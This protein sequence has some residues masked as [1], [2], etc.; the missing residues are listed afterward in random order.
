MEF[1]Y[2]DEDLDL[3]KA[4]TDENDVKNKELKLRKTFEKV[5]VGNQ[6]I[7]IKGRRKTGK[8]ILAMEIIIQNLLTNPENEALFINTYGNFNTRTFSELCESYIKPCAEKDVEGAVKK[9]MKRLR[10]INT[11]CE[12]NFHD[13][14]SCLEAMILGFSK[15]SLVVVDSFSFYFHDAFVFEKV[16]GKPLTREMYLNY[17][18]NIFAKLVKQ[19]NI[20]II[21]TLPQHLVKQY[22][23]SRDYV[24]GETEAK[25][26][27]IYEHMKLTAI[28]NSEHRFPLI[29]DTT[30]AGFKFDRH[31]RHREKF[32]DDLSEPDSS[33]SKVLTVKILPE[34]KINKFPE[35]DN[36]EQEPIKTGQSSTSDN[37][38]NM[39][40]FRDIN[41]ESSDSLSDANSVKSGEGYKSD[42]GTTE[43]SVASEK[44]SEKI[45]ATMYRHT[46]PDVTLKLLS[47]SPNMYM[48]QITTENQNHGVYFNITE[49]GIIWEITPAEN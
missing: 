25:E 37:K 30:L 22:T 1:A 11:E 17:Y 18:L 29:A 14:L 39:H 8:S 7:C 28:N 45:I 34:I 16:Y 42:T 46:K 2:T 27:K 15:L 47:V 41:N 36:N 33:S 32:L 3:N 23:N 31:T 35:L 19:Y 21:Y 12:T 44:L 13:Y 26:R 4:A 9:I 24:E 40:E 48:M 5:F 20:T 49:N 10:V 6:I 38:S 43:S